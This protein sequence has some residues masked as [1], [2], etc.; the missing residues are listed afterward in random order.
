MT[1][2]MATVPWRRG[3]RLSPAIWH[4]RLSGL[5]PPESAGTTAIPSPPRAEVTGKQGA[6]A[7]QRKRSRG[8]GQC[9]L[10]Q[11]RRIGRPLGPERM[12]VPAPPV[13]LRPL[14]GFYNGDGA[15]LN[16]HCISLLPKLSI[17]QEGFCACTSLQDSS[18]QP[19]RH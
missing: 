16:V 1:L 7:L 13:P 8:G 12:E 11:E 10:A 14:W 17:D 5:G 6:E 9:I 15:F 19:F 4:P 3:G 18:P 2:P